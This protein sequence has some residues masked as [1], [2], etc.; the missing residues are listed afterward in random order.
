MLCEDCGKNQASVVITVTTGGQSTT[1]HLCAACMEKM[2]QSFT[3]GDVQSFLSSLLQ[4]L[5]NEPAAP[6]LSCSGCGLSY[7]EF[8]H[9]GKLGCAQCYRD[10]AEELRPLLLRIHG[11][12]QHAGRVP[13]SREKARELEQCVDELRG[14]MDKAVAE[15]NFEMAARLRDEIRAITERRQ[16]E[17]QP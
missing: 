7:A 2:K 14:K 9:T 10:F 1:R 17:G 15:E 5:N 8:Q 3:Q 16:T 11:R 12:S 4:L 13:P 6:S